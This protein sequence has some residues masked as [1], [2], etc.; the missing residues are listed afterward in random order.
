MRKGPAI[1]VAD[2]TLVLVPRGANRGNQWYPRNPRM[3][4]QKG[5]QLTVKGIQKQ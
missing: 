5:K 4:L 2:T 1:N 3:T